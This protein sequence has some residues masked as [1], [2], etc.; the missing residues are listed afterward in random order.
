MSCPCA[1][2]VTWRGSNHLPARTPVGQIW[3]SHASHSARV[4]GSGTPPLQHRTDC[5]GVGLSGLCWAWAFVQAPAPIYDTH[6]GRTPAAGHRTEGGIVLTV[7]Q[8]SQGSHTAIL[9]IHELLVIVYILCAASVWPASQGSSTIELWQWGPARS[10]FRSQALSKGGGPLP[11]CC[12]VTGSQQKPS[13]IDRTLRQTERRSRS[14][15]GWVKQQSSSATH[16]QAE[17]QQPPS[18]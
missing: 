11:C 1:K 3:P 8:C 4:Q 5:C 15:I 10:N 2:A 16:A 9:S 12:L 6:L 17:K 13:G 18:P 7:P 14:L